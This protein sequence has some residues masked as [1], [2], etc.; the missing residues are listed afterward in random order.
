M[1]LN[2]RA[3][4]WRFNSDTHASHGC[5]LTYSLAPLKTN[6]F[7]PCFFKRYSISQALFSAWF[8][9]SLGFACWRYAG[10]YSFWPLALVQ[11]AQAAIVLVVLRSLGGAMLFRSSCPS[12]NPSYRFWLLAL[13]FRSSRPAFC[14]RLTSPV[15]T[16]EIQLYFTH[17][18]TNGNQF[19]KRCA[20][21]GLPF[22]WASPAGFS[23]FSTLPLTR[24]SS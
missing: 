6:L 24:Q 14:G 10:F 17:A 9:V 11:Q 4:N 13:T 21:L 18:F 8:A 2:S 23:S 16:T 20:A 12:P 3:A 5:R 22:L 1:E 7:R 15:S 19:L